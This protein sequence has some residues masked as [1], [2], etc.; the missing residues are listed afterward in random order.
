M[1]R[2]TRM[3]LELDVV[4]LSGDVNTVCHHRH[5]TEQGELVLGQQA[6]G[7]GAPASVLCVC[8]MVVFSIAPNYSGVGSEFSALVIL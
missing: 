3:Y 2:L 8:A 1:T 7:G 6:C 4:A 5:L